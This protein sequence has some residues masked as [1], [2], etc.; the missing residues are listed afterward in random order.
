MRELTNTET[1]SIAGG[2]TTQLA[3]AAI[4]VLITAAGTASSVYNLGREIGH[5]ISGFD[6]NLTCS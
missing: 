5:Q 6:D 2:F 4:G 1:V 3:I